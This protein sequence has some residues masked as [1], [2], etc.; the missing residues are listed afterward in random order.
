LAVTRAA[1][2]VVRTLFDLESQWSDDR[3]LVWPSADRA[4]GLDLTH[5]P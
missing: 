3:P 5:S 2:A 1:A 4:V